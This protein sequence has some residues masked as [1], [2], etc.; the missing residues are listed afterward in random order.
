MPDGFINIYKPS[1][2]TSMEAVRQIKQHLPKV[3]IGHCGTLDPIAEGVLPIAIGKASRIV[4]YVLHESKTYKATIKLGESTNTYDSEGTVTETQST[5]EVTRHI[6]ENILPEYLGNIKQVPPIYS[7][8]KK[9]GKPLYKYA[10]AGE[11]V[12]IAAREVYIHSIDILDLKVPLVDL[13]IQCGAGTYIRSFAHDLGRSLGCGAHM[14]GL[15]REVSSGFQLQEATH[16]STIREALQEDPAAIN[17]YLHPIDSPISYIPKIGI[18]HNNAVD[19]S[20]GKEIGATPCKFEVTAP[21]TLSRAYDTTGKF[22]AIVSYNSP[23]RTWKPL[24]VFH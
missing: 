14:I 3:K 8:L 12:E 4:E 22:M 10:R 21:P 24:K 20:N 11:Q 5:S 9:A 19:L 13:R 2:I 1:G 15:I 16:L 18:S 7:A 6:I 23:N 17:Q